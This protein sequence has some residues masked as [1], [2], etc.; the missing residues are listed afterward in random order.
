VKRSSTIVLAVAVGVVALAAGLF[1]GMSYGK[2][3]PSVETAMETV[4]N[5][6]P[7]QMAQL[8]TSGGGFPGGGFPG[9]GFPGGAAGDGNGN[10]RGGFTA[11]SI[12]SNDGSTITIKMNDGSTKFVLYSGSTT[13][14]KSAEGTSADLVAGENVVV[15]GSANS[16]GSI[17]ATQIQLGGLPGG[18]GGGGQG[19]TPPTT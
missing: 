8:G 13:I 17:T 4:S 12:V 19:T 16:D 15:T 11:G 10:A 1:V 18:P 6:T 14:R 9:G 2:G 5:L 3:H 7:E